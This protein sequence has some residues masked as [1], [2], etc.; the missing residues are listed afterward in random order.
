MPK[1][2]KT[3]SKAFLFDAEHKQDTVENLLMGFFKGTLRDIS[4]FLWQTGDEVKRPR[5]ANKHEL[6]RVNE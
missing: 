3:I 4:I 1:T 2:L 6:I 5:I